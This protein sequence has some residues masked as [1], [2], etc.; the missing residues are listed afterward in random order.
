[1]AQVPLF[2]HQASMPRSSGGALANEPKALPRVNVQEATAGLRALI[3]ANRSNIASSE[4]A[5]NIMGQYQYV[6]SEVGR[7]FA[8]IAQAGNQ[9]TGYAQR[10]HEAEQSKLL[11]QATV[12]YEETLAKKQLELSQRTDYD[13]FLPEWEKTQDEA[14]KSLRQSLGPNAQ[15]VFDQKASKAA[16]SGYLRVAERTR[17]LQV[18][19]HLSALG[20]DLDRLGRL[21]T[22]ADPE[23]LARY[24]TT[25][26]QRLGAAVK[27]GTI[28][29]ET[30]RQRYNSF[31]KTVATTRLERDADRSSAATVL[32][33][34]HTD[35]SYYGGLQPADREAAINGLEARVRRDASTKRSERTEAREQ[36]K[37]QQDTNYMGALKAMQDPKSR[38]TE[39]DVWQ[40]AARGEIN[41]TQRKDLT[42]YLN[43]GGGSVAEFNRVQG[44]VLLAN[45]GYDVGKY[46]LHSLALPDQISFVM[47]NENLS[48]KHKT[49]LLG[50]IKAQAT[51]DKRPDVNQAMRQVDEVLDK[52]LDSEKY[53][54]D[55][56][57]QMS[58]AKVQAKENLRRKAEAGDKITV[59]EVMQEMARARDTLSPVLWET[60]P[61]PRSAFGTKQDLATME[62]ALD[63][64]RKVNQAYKSGRIDW[65]TYQDEYRKINILVGLRQLSEMQKQSGGSVWKPDPAMEKKAAEMRAR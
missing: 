40:M 8:N 9:V 48:Q 4:R 55:M 42:A 1:M 31:Y 45:Q 30:A 51:L 24:L 62:G 14:R 23:A 22:D 65:D 32:H 41:T 54:P 38:W 17:S 57:L 5:Y 58:A 6:Q 29:P 20:T 63:M 36:Y 37:F 43:S 59:Y 21:S 33:Q 7:A 11:G 46:G 15:A 12:A 18:Q 2:Q 56:R 25:A 53:L 13:K 50:E 35:P 27:A 64:M 28:T 19:D 61:G 34:M 16:L 39:Q 44:I 49:I 47:Q 60:A 3:D 10:M 52:M 26:D